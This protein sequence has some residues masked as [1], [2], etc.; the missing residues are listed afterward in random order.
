MTQTSRETN[1]SHSTT[2]LAHS[3]IDQTAQSAG[4]A[5]QTTQRVAND[6]V[7]SL[8]HTLQTAQHQVRDSAHLAS[9]K[10]VA[11]IREE[12]VKSMLIAAAAGAALMA[13]AR[14]I[15]QPRGSR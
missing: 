7:G 4:A 13:L 3:L 5:I 2:E 12:P 14:A 9:D 15:S 8:S 11:Y 6:A 10:T 1:M